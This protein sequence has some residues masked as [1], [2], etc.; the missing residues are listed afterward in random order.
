[1]MPDGSIC[2]I[3]LEQATSSVINYATRYNQLMES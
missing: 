3:A 2:E 1:M